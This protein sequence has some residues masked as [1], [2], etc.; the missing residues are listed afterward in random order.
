M[1]MNAQF[2][3]QPNVDLM[4]SF[5]TEEKILVVVQIKISAGQVKEVKNLVTTSRKK[6]VIVS[7]KAR[8]PCVDCFMVI[9]FQFLALK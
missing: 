8:V 5:A 7:L 2:H 1:D 6:F 9:L 3:A 4:N